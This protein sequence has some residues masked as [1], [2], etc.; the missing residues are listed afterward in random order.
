M[1]FRQVKL[2][3]DNSVNRSEKNYITEIN[4]MELRAIN[5]GIKISLPKNINA[6]LEAKTTTGKIY[7]EFPITIIG[8]ISKKQINGRLNNGGQ[9]IYLKTVTGSIEILSSKIL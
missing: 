8:E 4:G 5:G 7:T 1:L 2:I 3:N 6:D 9:L